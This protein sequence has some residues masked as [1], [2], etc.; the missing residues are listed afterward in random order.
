MDPRLGYEAQVHELQHVE[1]AE[2]AFN[3]LLDP[4]DAAELLVTHA[5]VPLCDDS[6]LD[7]VL[8][9]AQRFGQSARVREVGEAESVSA[10]MAWGSTQLQ[11]AFA[12]PRGIV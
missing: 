10:P 5:V 6:L 8:R 11:A 12:P 9:N 2:H 4:A 3:E 1:T 7:R